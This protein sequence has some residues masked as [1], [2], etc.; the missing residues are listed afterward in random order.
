MRRL[1]IKLIDLEVAFEA[2][3]AEMHHYLAMEA[4]EALMVTDDFRR[5]LERLWEKAAPKDKLEDLLRKSKLP[6]W[7]KQALA[8]ARRVEE[9]YGIRVVSVP[10]PDVHI[11]RAHAVHGTPPGGG[12]QKLARG[13]VQPARSRSLWPSHFTLFLGSCHR[14]AP[15]SPG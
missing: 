5:E 1:R 6:D 11:L 10:E 2:S 8:E 14:L 3:S 15:R 12:W 13:C 7:Q 4:E 9:D